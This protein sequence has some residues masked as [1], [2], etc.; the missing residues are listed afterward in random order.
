MIFQYVNIYFVMTT[1]F[2]TFDDVVS[3][4]T[5]LEKYVS[6]IDVIM[7]MFNSTILDENDYD[8]NDSN[9]LFFI[10]LYYEEV[11]IDYDK[12]LYYYEKASNLNNADAL[13]CLGYYYETIEKDYYKMKYYYEKSSNLNSDYAN[14]NL[15]LYY[16]DIEKNIDKMLYYYKINI[17][18]SDEDSMYNFRLY[19]EKKM[20]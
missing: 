1:K 4:H 10:G 5:I 18:L 3:N 8:L 20:N 6:Y 15:A 13:F 16:R 7:N 9:I 17:E 12:M 11:K 14:Y 2:N 19:F